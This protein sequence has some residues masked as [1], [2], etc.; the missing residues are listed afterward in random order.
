MHGNPRRVQV[1]RCMVRP[2][3]R[4]TMIRMERL[5]G[6]L[7]VGAL[8]GT[9]ACADRGTLAGGEGETDGG[10]ST[11]STTGTTEP[12]DEGG[13]ETDTAAGTGGSTGTEG[14]TE[15]TGE[16]EEGSTGGS[17][18]IRLDAGLD[19][20]TGGTTSGGSCDPETDETCHCSA[21]DVLLVIDNSA[22]MAERQTALAL[23]LPDF[24]DELVATLPAGT[25][26]QLGATS[27]EMAYTSSGSSSDCVATSRG[28][29]MEASYVTPDVENTGRNGAQGRLYDPGDG[30][31]YLEAQ[32]DDANGIDQLKEWSGSLVLLGT[33]G[34][35]IEMVTAPMAWVADPINDPTNAGF[36]RDEGAVA[37]LFFLTDE[38]DQSPLEL[39][40]APG[41]EVLL[42]K[43][44]ESKV[45]C[46]GARCVVAGGFSSE[47]CLEETAL[48]DFVG[49]LEAPLEAAQFGP[50]QSDPTP[51]NEAV[52]DLMVRRFAR[53]VV[54]R[55]RS[56]PAP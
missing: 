43:F 3:I 41:G 52:R 26:L 11:D 51:T 29:P 2:E 53:A 18:G 35:N 44:L 5:Y 33:G 54:D 32:T 21:V 36:I 34:S 39:G 6:A 23:A 10:A 48:G 56:I 28:E 42:E 38:F 14:S 15:T 46:G 25:S 50:P 9:L 1:L 40:G 17:G 47:T 4:S 13:R 19:T 45:G 12:D 24:I 37:A 55:C 49:G 8:A 20:E 31:T 16:S 22:S 7:G 27:T 30:R